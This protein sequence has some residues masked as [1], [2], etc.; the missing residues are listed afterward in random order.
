MHV[1]L[2]HPPDAAGLP[3]PWRITGRLKVMPED[4]CV[5]EIPLPAA[6]TNVAAT[7]RQA[8]A[9]P[10]PSAPLTLTDEEWAPLLALDQQTREAYAAARTATA[11]SS[12]SSADFL[13]RLQALATDLPCP[14]NTSRSQRNAL[15]ASIR[16]RCPYL[17]P[18]QRQ[19]TLHVAA[20][21][22]LADV[23]V[24]TALPLTCVEALLVYKHRGPHHEAAHEGL[25]VGYTATFLKPSSVNADHSVFTHR[26]GEG[27]GESN[28]PKCTE[29]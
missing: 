22:T 15:A 18:A 29:N 17:Y 8:S 21:I 28:A 3:P 9:Q 6:T 14:A 20:D 24:G 25:E 11:S 23:V 10:P 2:V 7:S 1:N 5:T 27:S 19:G 26:L 16:D 13:A 4:F 12:L